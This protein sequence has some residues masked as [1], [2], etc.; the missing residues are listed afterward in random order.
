ML[1]QLS[2]GSL[3]YEGTKLL[4][5]TFAFVCVFVCLFSKIMKEIIDFLKLIFGHRKKKI[6]WKEVVKTY[7]NIVKGAAA[8]I[9]QTHMSEV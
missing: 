5:V 2:C 6:F 3:S 1:D 9:L 4:K 7:L 8:M